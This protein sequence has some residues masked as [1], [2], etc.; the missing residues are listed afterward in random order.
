MLRPRS[1]RLPG[2]AGHIRFC[3][4]VALMATLAGSAAANPSFITGVRGQG[5]TGAMVS[6]ADQAAQA[7]YYNPAALTYVPSL[8]F[9]FAAIGN[10]GSGRYEPPGG[11]APTDAEIKGAEPGLAIASSHCMVENVGCGF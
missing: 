7:V 9:E 4:G 6:T 2:I 10:L 1:G 5:L 8:T 3:L 11:V